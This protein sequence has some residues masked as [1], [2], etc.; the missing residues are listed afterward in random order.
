[1]TKGSTSRAV[2]QEGPRR[3]RRLQFP[4][5]QIGPEDALLRVEACGICGSDY[6]QYAG[7]L[8]APFPVIPDEEAIHIA[9]VP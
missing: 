9:L 1:M 2:V 4:L 7:V 6:E 3:L 5:P 8:P